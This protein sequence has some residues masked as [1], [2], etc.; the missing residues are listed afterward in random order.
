MLSDVV[1][2]PSL[3]MVTFVRHTFLNSAH[4]L[5]IKENISEN[6]IQN[7]SDKCVEIL[8]LNE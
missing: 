3:A 1:H 8:L 6:F 5:S 2:S 4:A 7:K